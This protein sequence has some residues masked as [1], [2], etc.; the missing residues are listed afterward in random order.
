MILPV[1][2][3]ERLRIRPFTPNDLDNAH[4]LY[5]QIGWVDEEQTPAEQLAT[6]HR[7]VQWNSLNHITLAN[8]TQPP[9]GDRIVELK[10]S[11][12]FVGACGIGA[13]WLPMG[14]LPSFG[15]QAPSF[16]QAEV[17]LMWAISP[18]HQGSGYATEAARALINTLFTQFN[19]K[20][21]IAT[22][23]YDNIASLRVMEKAGMRLERNP[24]PDP[25]WFQ[26]VGVIEQENPSL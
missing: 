26:I 15:G 14:Q 16:M 1:L 8:L 22:T 12:E 21:I 13:L 5:T 17:G 7:Y 20:R 2:A 3:T 9:T 6:R 18:A 23:E 24:F 19:L 4:Q 10:S 11:G 25:F